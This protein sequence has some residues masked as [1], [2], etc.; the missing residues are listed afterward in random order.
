[1]KTVTISII[2]CTIF[3]PI[4]FAGNIDIWGYEKDL[5]QKIP[6]T[7][8][9]LIIYGRYDKNIVNFETNYGTKINYTFPE[10]TKLEDIAKFTKENVGQD[11]EIK[12]ENIQSA[13][14]TVFNMKVQ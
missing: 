1:M 8:K 4:Y 3:V 14:L 5:E 9:E 2:I 12:I 6:F 7:K 13:Y 11:I 10:N